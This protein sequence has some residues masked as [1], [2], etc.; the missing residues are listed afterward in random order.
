MAVSEFNQLLKNNNPKIERGITNFDRTM[1]ELSETSIAA[2]KSVNQIEDFVTSDSIRITLHQVSEVVDKLNKANIYTI[3]QNINLAVEQMNEL[4]NQMEHVL[5]YNLTLFNTTMEQ[6]N[7]TSQHLNNAA[8][9]I[10]ANPS[11]LLF[12]DSEPENPPDKQLEQ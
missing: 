5:K 1:M 6:L 8:R 2:N 9:K 12:G 3:D 10:D 11:I 4:L 7:E